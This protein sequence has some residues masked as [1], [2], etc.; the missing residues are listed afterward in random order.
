[1]KQT[2]LGADRYDYEKR[3]RANILLCIVLLCAM[4]VIHAL[5]IC[6]RTT[7]N[8]TAMLICN[9]AVDILGGSFLL[10]RLNLCILPQKKL[11]QLYD[12][13][14]QEATGQVLEINTSMI[15]YIGV[16]CYEISLPDRQLFLPAETMVLHL[17]KEYR[18]RLKGNLI[19]EVCDHES[20]Q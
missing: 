15:H 9:I 5:C 7:N 13:A 14:A 3:L 12:R 17:G 11:L 8:H 10:A 19:V 2:V 20:C 16:D 4:V 6:L 1:M 18:F